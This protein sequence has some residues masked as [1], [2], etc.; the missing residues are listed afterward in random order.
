MVSKHGAS[1]GQPTGLV[2]FIL[3]GKV[4]PLHAMKAQSERRY[5]THP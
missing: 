2:V 3:K 4:V 1:N 5:I